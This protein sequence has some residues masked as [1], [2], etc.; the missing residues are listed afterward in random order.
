MTMQR[1]KSLRGHIHIRLV[2]LS[3][4]AGKGLTC[5]VTSPLARTCSNAKGDRVGVF[6]LIVEECGD[7]EQ[8]PANDLLAHADAK[9]QVGTVQYREL[10]VDAAGEKTLRILVS[11]R[12]TVW[13][14]NILERV[15][16]CCVTGLK[17]I[18]IMQINSDTSSKSCQRN[19]ILGSTVCSDF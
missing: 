12:Q 19:S 10:D 6:L 5:G 16:S 17:F 7:P 15:F 2:L 4:V 3:H 14:N 1:F 13:E 18:F 11:S 8:A 9:Q